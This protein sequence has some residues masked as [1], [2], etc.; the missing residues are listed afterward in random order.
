MEKFYKRYKI[1]EVVFY[2]RVFPAVLAL[3]YLISIKNFLA[4]KIYVFH[5][6]LP[7]LSDLIISQSG[8][9]VALPQLRSFHQTQSI[10]TW[11]N[12]EMRIGF[13]P[14]SIMYFT[15]LK[16][17]DFHILQVEAWRIAIIYLF[18]VLS[19]V[20]IGKFLELNQFSQLLL[21]FMLLVSPFTQSIWGQGAG[22]LMPFKFVPITILF[23]L[24]WCKNWRKIDFVVGSI[25]LG[26]MTQSYQA[27]YALFVM[28]VI[29]IVFLSKDKWRAILAFCFQHQLLVLSSFSW[30]VVSSLPLLVAYQET[31]SKFIALP[32][33]VMPSRITSPGR[34]LV[35]YLT[36]GALTHGMDQCG[37]DIQVFF[38]LVFS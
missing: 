13:D 12:S 14:F 6:N 30:L 18:F 27:I 4:G 38:F 34:T 31:T 33:I 28:A 21:M 22:F 32:R 37:R 20:W 11:Q 10:P 15:I 35:K 1:F 23:F 16:N 36:L 2:L 9:N 7:Y 5:D 29:C 8:P 17:F 25:F 24:K 3:G 19:V 26:L